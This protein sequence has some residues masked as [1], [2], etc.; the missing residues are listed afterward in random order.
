MCRPRILNTLISAVSW[1]YTWGDV[2][3]VC[4]RL[5]GSRR[6][7]LRS[8]RTAGKHLPTYIRPLASPLPF[9]EAEVAPC[10]RDVYLESDYRLLPM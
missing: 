2:I 9:D 10:D 3:H 6:Q 5:G 4:S 1:L 7:V 8:G